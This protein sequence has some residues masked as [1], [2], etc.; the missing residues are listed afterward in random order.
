ME[1]SKTNIK[2][3]ELI[4]YVHCDVFLHSLKSGILS[5]VEDREP[6]K[7][8]FLPELAACVKFSPPD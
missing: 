3:D 4:L 1:E 7:T 6:V 2:H 8:S 5:C